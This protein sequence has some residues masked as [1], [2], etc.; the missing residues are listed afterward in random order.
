MANFAC[1]NDYLIIF[2]TLDYQQF[3]KIRGRYGSQDNCFSI[4]MID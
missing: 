3:T 4:H 1:K 2:I